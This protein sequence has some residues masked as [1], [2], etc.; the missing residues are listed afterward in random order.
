[1]LDPN[2]RTHRPIELGEEPYYSI[3]I[4]STHCGGHDRISVL[5]SLLLYRGISLRG[6]FPS[7][8]YLRT[9]DEERATTVIV[10]SF[11]MFSQGKS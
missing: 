8:Q 1:M 7:Y 11:A 6:L 10:E 2:Y 5:I 9:I 4:E 3:P